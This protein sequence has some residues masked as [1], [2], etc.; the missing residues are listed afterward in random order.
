MRVRPDE[1]IVNRREPFID[2][3]LNRKG[4]VQALCGVIRQVEGSA[5]VA[6]NGPFGSGKSVFLKMCAAHLR[7]GGVTVAEFNAWQQSHTS[8]PLVD[9]VAALTPTSGGYEKLQKIAVNLSWRVLSVA[10]HGVVDREDFQEPEDGSLFGK[11]AK[12]EER[13]NDFRKALAELAKDRGGRLVVFIDELD[14]CMPM[15]ALE[16]LNAVRHLF[17]QRGIVIVLGINTDELHHRV[18]TLYG[19]DCK[20][21]VFL[22]RF[23]DLS[24]D[25][26]DPSTELL[27]EFLDGTLAGADISERLPADEYSG[28]MARLLAERSGMSLR[29]IEQMAHRLACVLALVPTPDRSSGGPFPTHTRWAEEQATVALFALRMAAPDAYRKFLLNKIDGFD[30]VAALMRALSI[31]SNRAK[32][33]AP[34][35]RMIVSLIEVGSPHITSR[36]QFDERFEA[37]GVG[38]TDLA[39][40]LWRYLG[41]LPGEFSRVA[42]DELFDLVELV[43]P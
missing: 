23:I 41:E 3:K 7:E 38:N 11:W 12:T 43:G 13:R 6:V 5:V 40:T 15:H 26:P 14:R 19:Q 35:I 28:S 39:D 9:L 17:D 20:A 42:L 37:A 2:D 21:E 36:E 24:I 10:T 29:D 16:L 30:A 22:R 8:V 4:R 18:R 33:R 1:F 25:L 31:D 32:A 27:T 34:I